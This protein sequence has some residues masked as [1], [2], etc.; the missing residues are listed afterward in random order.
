MR[1]EEPYVKR[2]GL[3]TALAITMHNFPEGL[4]TFFATLEGSRVGLPPVLAIA[5]H[6]IRTGFGE[7][8]LRPQAG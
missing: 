7:R 1:V 8:S 4:A 6:N 5:I 2:V 3:L